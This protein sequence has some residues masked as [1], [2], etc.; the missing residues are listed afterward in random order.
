MSEAKDT[1]IIYVNAMQ[2]K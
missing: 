1:K 2:I